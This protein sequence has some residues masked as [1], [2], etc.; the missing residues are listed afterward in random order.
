MINISLLKL[1]LKPVLAI[2]IHSSL[3]VLLKIN[4]TIGLTLVIKLV[5]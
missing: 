5:R 3:T 2:L 1:Y 4:P